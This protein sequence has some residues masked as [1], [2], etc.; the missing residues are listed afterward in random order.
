M[1]FL[2]Q[3]KVHTLKC[4]FY[5]KKV[6]ML[7]PAALQYCKRAAGIFMFIKFLCYF[8]KDFSLLGLA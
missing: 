7:L 4:I 3:K 1:H 8:Q 2:W 5:G 6:N